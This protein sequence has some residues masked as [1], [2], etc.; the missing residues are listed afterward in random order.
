MR[1]GVFRNSRYD[2]VPLIDGARSSKK[3]PT[4]GQ[5]QSIVAVGMT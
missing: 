2:T 5:E 1:L 4:A 3:S